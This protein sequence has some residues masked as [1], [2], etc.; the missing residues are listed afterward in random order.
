MEVK[1]KTILLKCPQFNVI[2]FQG[3]R[4]VWWTG[5]CDIAEEGRWKW[6][7]SLE[8]VQESVQLSADIF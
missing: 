3:V 5:G 6:I 7:T 8:L 1:T 4:A 2:P